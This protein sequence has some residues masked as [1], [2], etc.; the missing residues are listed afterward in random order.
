[1]P[2]AKTKVVKKTISPA[3]AEVLRALTGVIEPVKTPPAYRL[4]LILVAPLMVLLPV[5]YAGL[6]VL[7]GYGTY[8][9]AWIVVPYAMTRSH[10]GGYGTLILLA[11]LGAGIAAIAFMLKPLIP[12]RSLE[13]PHLLTREAEPVFFEFVHRVAKAVGAPQPRQ[14]KV[15]L[16]VNA[17]AGFR[18]GIRSFFGHDLVLTVGLPLLAGL[19]T[20]QLAGVLA[21][22]F[23]HFTQGTGLRF[24]YIIQSINIWFARQVYEKDSWDATIDRMGEAKSLPLKFTAALAKALVWATR[25]VLWVFMQA[26]LVVSSFLARQQE[27]DADRY[28]AR[29]TGSGQYANTSKRMAMLSVAEGAAHQDLSDSWKSGHLCD[30]LAQLVL[31]NAAQIP[32]DV[33]G[34]IEKDLAEHKAHLFDTHPCHGDRVRNVADEPPD[35]LFRVEHPAAILFT[36][37]AKISREVTFRHYQSILGDSVS[38]KNLVSFD[39]TKAQQEDTTEDFKALR[40]YW[41]GALTLRHLAAPDNTLLVAAD[42]PAEPLAQLSASHTRLEGMIPAVRAAITRHAKA[43]DF[44][45]ESKQAQAAVDAGLNLD[46]SEDS[47]IT[48]RK[49]LTRVAAESQEGLKALGEAVRPF[50]AEEC[51]RLTLGLR[52]LVSPGPAAGLK[53]LEQLRDEAAAIVPAVQALASHC[54]PLL[55]LRQEFLIL[56]ALA[57]ALQPNEK[58][59]TLISSIRMRMGLVRGCLMKLQE[60]L[61]SLAYPLAHADGT[62]TIGQYA[63]APLPLDEANLGNLMEVA[64][65]TLDRLYRLYFLGMARLAAT[66]EQVEAAAGLPPL[67][68]PEEPAAAPPA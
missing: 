56:A 59:T 30:D 28:Q 5:L 29:M 35:G 25:K 22:E 7:I 45:I 34:R 1:M 50:L 36:D 33:V 11:P 41:Q 57:R 55:A 17:S 18:R 58:R 43:E 61:A 19:N 9:Y 6:A 44:F 10:G 63:F 15:T 66:A 65:G 46:A 4:G 31:H 62:I 32:H 49:S 8:L 16:E 42:D 3:A 14:I 60:P 26:G 53:N 12:K 40:R 38:E 64:D 68:M 21:H 54:E 37:L 47:G 48:D 52:L 27:Y 67:P 51:V 23:G 2:A 24:W 13:Q 20:R 39:K